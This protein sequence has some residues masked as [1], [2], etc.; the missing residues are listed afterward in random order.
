[1]SIKDKATRAA[2]FA[3]RYLT[4]LPSIK[5]SA[6]SVKGS[7]DRTAERI[8]QAR[9]AAKAKKERID[10]ARAV[11]AEF[12]AS[13]PANVSEADKFRAYG[14]RFG[15]DEI[16]LAEHRTVHRRMKRIYLFFSALCVYGAIMAVI[17]GGWF[18]PL[19]MT[20]IMLFGMAVLAAA[21]LVEALRQTRIEMRQMLTLKQFMGRG[22]FF[23]RLVV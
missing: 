22:D 1:M 15:W 14:E 5:R 12:V 10:Q 3:V 13:L 6:G 7:V 8:E 21:A 9:A 18:F 19:F 16:G 20:P 4:P 11:E 2:K 23:R 17:S